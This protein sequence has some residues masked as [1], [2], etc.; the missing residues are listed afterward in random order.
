M[1]GDKDVGLIRR[2]DRAVAIAAMDLAFLKTQEAI[3]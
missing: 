3:I 2:G 1:W